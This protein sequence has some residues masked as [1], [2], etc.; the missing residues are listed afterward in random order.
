MGFHHLLLKGNY[1]YD[2]LVKVPLIVK[3]PHQVR[4]GERSEALVNNIDLAP[5]LLQCAGC[6]VPSSMRG[7]DLAAN[8]QGRAL[9]FAE[10]WGGRA[11]MVRSH[12]H[13][14]LLCQDGTQ[15][16]FF[17]LERDPLE[18][19]NSIADRVYQAKIVEL[20]GALSRWALF[21]APSQVYRDDCA[22]VIEG[23]NVPIRGDGH[24]AR[25]YDYFRLRMSEPFRAI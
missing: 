16:Q 4:A 21:E 13:K 19:A 10:G 11:Y 3:F 24:E 18:L 14:L 23:D 9:V 1:M 22:P 17:D 6:D 2:P 8:V 12:K 20:T 7:M 5:T 25:G 15:S